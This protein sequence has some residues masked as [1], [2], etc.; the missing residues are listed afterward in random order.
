MPTWIYLGLWLVTALVLI[1]FLSA[2]IAKHLKMRQLRREQAL[3]LLEALE[4]YGAWVASQRYTPVFF[5]ESSEA[6][7]ALDEACL[8][9]MGWFPELSSDIA[10]L[11]GV[12]NRLLH[13]LNS[14]H[15]LRQ[16]DPEGWLETEHDG[17]F[18][19]LWRQQNC[20]VR[21]IQVKLS[22]LGSMSVV[23]EVITGPV[24]RVQESNA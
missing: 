3:R 11:L 8:V 4:R 14:Q 18:L 16:R 6:A 7:E 10:E 20:V 23:E 13:F 12:H 22:A 9:R 24:P 1:A 15:A 17:R 5:G 2:G 19:A 21:S